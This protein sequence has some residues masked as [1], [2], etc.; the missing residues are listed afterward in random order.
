MVQT[1]RFRGAIGAPPSAAFHD[2]TFESSDG[3]HLSGWYATSKN[4]AAIIIVSSSRGDRMG[5]VQHAELLAR[6]GYGVLIYD[7]RGTGRSAG[8]PNGWGWGWSDDVDG[9]VAFLQGQADVDPTRVGALGLSTG[10]DAVI[11]AASRNNDLQAVVADGATARSFQDVMQVG[12]FSDLPF[13]WSMYTA[14]KVFSGSTPG[15]PLEELVAGVSPTPL[16]LVA[17]G[18][19]AQEIPLNAIYADSAREPVELWEL[20]DVHHTAAI[21]ERAAAYEQRVV[22]FLDEALVQQP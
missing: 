2:V 10:A 8:S 13:V 18:S 6:H 16:L 21:R 7:A 20:P 19:I 14:A 22:G 3:L 12:G 15:R 11:E 5:S 17:S 4:G 9:A 1:H